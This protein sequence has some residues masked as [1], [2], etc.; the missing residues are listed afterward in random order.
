MLYP[1]SLID[2][3]TKESMCAT[4]ATEIFGQGNFLSSSSAR[5]QI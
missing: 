2:Q 1:E 4:E 3:S 5:R